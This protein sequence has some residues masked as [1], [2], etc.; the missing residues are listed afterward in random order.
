MIIM[1]FLKNSGVT[2]V[3][4]IGVNHEGDLQQAK[5]ILQL[6]AE[7]GVDY[8]KFQSYT[9]S[10]YSTA[11]DN[12][13]FNRITKF[14]LKQED[15]KLLAQLAS[16]LGVGFFSTPV[17][18]D[19]VDIL[20]EFCP[21]FKIASGD[22]SFKPVIQKV[23]QKGKPFMISTG[24]ATI[25]EID[26]AVEWVQQ[27]VGTKDLKNHLI[28]MHCVSAYPTPIDQANLLSIPF[29]RDRYGVRIGYS[30]H[31]IG[32]NACLAA[33]ALG[34]EV[35]EIHFT[36]RKDGRE[37]RDHALSFD[38]NDLKTFIQISHDI[39]KSL[40]SYT[41]QVQP[42]EKDNIPMFR[43]GIIAACDLKKGHVLL[44]NDL[45]FARPATE[46]AASE[47]NALIGK[48]LKVDVPKGFL[49][50]RNAI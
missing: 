9:P 27:E 25:E 8:V 2:I 34:A 35:I 50:P 43:K 36:D 40:G 46:F 11:Q 17:T 26:Q 31:V 10:R 21:V 37:F 47:I 32:M 19:W 15:F 22:I 42:C 12:V 13:R 4:E 39:R 20:D 28:L 14:A 16:D 30:N 44:D 6:A 3:A 29:L 18:E 41:K 45:M 24:T 7:A 1:N 5:K 49:I 33:V 23:A 38:Q 48:T